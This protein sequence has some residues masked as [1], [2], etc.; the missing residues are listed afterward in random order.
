MKLSVCLNNFILFTL[1][2]LY[3]V[4]TCDV[5]VYSLKDRKTFIYNIIPFLLYLS[6]SHEDFSPV[7][8]LLHLLYD[9]YVSKIDFPTLRWSANPLVCVQQHLHTSWYVLGVSH[10][11]N[12]FLPAQGNV[13]MRGVQ[14]RQVMCP[15]HAF[16]MYSCCEH[17]SKMFQKRDFRDFQIHIHPVLSLNTIL[18]R[19][20]RNHC[21]ILLLS[22][23]KCWVID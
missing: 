2:W 18:T 23:M 12:K 15:V 17:L 19:F 16:F 7:S 5:S 3:F 21:E 1:F 11:K 22:G 13:R 6:I 14:V 8:P 20:K 9:K 4:H 10:S